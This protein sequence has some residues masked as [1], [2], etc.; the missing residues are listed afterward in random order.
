MQLPPEII[1]SILSHVPSFREK[2]ELS[3]VSTTFRIAFRDLQQLELR[4][5]EKM[6]RIGIWSI[7]SQF[8]RLKSLILKA[9]GSLNEDKKHLLEFASA[10]LP[11]TN[12]PRLYSLQYIY[13]E[14]SAVLK[15]LSLCCSRVTEIV[16]WETV[17]MRKFL[18]S[19]F[20]HCMINIKF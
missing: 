7:L 11:S 16:L 5:T 20:P 10:P 1:S 13:T 2:R 3:K 8:P 9:N 12:V 19:L 4:P 14:T 18:W 15:W 17:S 6:A